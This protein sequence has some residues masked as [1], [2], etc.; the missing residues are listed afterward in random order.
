[1]KQDIESYKN[2]YENWII[3]LN[4][5]KNKIEEEIKRNEEESQNHSE[6]L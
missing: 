4:V 2:E 3:D 1:L 6:K 5:R